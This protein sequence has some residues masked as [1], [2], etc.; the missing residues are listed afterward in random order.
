M[1]ID[2]SLSSWALNENHS[3][4]GELI[5]EGECVEEILFLLF[6]RQLFLLMGGDL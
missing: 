3:C 2:Q 4:V 6:N 5:N 1:A